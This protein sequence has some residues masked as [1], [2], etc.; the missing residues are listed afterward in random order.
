M[1]RLFKVAFLFIVVMAMCACGGG[2]TP[3]AVAEKAMDCF[4]DEDYEGYVDLIYIKNEDT[5]DKEKLEQD[6]KQY[7]AM[8]KEKVTKSAEKSGKKPKSAKAV[9]EEISEDGEKATVEMKI[10]YDD[11]T[12]DTN[13]MK[14]CKDKNGNW[15]VDAG[16]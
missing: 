8:L 3:S 2:N 16:K 10:T 1:K 12:E 13:K 9:S 5:R 15:R 4:V 7:V 11:G 6:K 14:M